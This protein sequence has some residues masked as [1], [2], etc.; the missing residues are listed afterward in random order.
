MLASLV[1]CGGHG[2][3]PDSAEPDIAQSAI[4]RHKGAADSEVRLLIN[5]RPIVADVAAL[6]REVQEL[7]HEQSTVSKQ[8][9]SA[10]AFALALWAFLI[11][12]RYHFDPLTAERW[13]HSPV[14]LL[15][16]IGFGLCDDAASAYVGLAR[17]AGFDARVW[18]I[19]GHV[20]PEINVDGRWEMYDPDLEVYYLN[21]AGGVCGVEE[22]AA[23]QDLITSPRIGTPDVLPGA[24]APSSG[25]TWSAP[26][27]A[28]ARY[29]KR[30]AD[31]YGTADDNSVHPWY[32]VIPGL[33]TPPC[34]VVLPA[35]AT[36]TLGL[37]K[38]PTLA[39]YWG[40]PLPVQGAVE[41]ALPETRYR[42]LQLPLVPVDIRGSGQVIIDAITYEIGGVALA[43]RLR[44]FA[45]PISVIDLVNCQAGTTV[46]YLL[47]AKRFSLQRIQEVQVEGNT[48]TI[49]LAYAH[50]SLD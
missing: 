25:W 20:V 48:G 39:G 15:N 44:D 6:L 43:L 35:G 38:T 29:A 1:G 33:A 10:R 37:R 41:L 23:R 49:E 17:S 46:E 36:L 28:Q 13:G 18:E 12:D 8:A 50:A 31:L 24:P 26:V 5:G 11:R 32:Q 45:A 16:S 47:N 2:D 42:R 22:L 19:N 14:L 40:T 27:S 21:D 34:A 3:D 30:L 9:S 7:R 4:L